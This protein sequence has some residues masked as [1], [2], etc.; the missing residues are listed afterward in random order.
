MSQHVRTVGGGW[1]V[2]ERHEKRQCVRVRELPMR[3][4][5][6]PLAPPSRPPNTSLLH[7]HLAGTKQPS[8]ALAQG[9]GEKWSERRWVEFSSGQPLLPGPEQR[10]DGDGGPGRVTAPGG[11]ASVGPSLHVTL[12]GCHGKLLMSG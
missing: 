11:L 12:P 6:A 2:S 9:R 8:V 3:L 4:Y 5:S 7:V 1:G 10:P